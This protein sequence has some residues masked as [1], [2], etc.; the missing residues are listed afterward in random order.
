MLL[1]VDKKVKNYLYSGSDNIN[2]V[3]HYKNNTHDGRYYIGKE[4]AK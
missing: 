4:K 2:E 3:A 1:E